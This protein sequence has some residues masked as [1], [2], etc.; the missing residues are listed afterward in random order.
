MR[1]TTGAVRCT[2]NASVGMFLFDGA[3]PPDGVPVLSATHPALSITWSGEKTR[4]RPAGGWQTG[5]AG[6]AEASGHPYFSVYR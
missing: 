4:G 5:R 2:G 1:D 3:P 6:R